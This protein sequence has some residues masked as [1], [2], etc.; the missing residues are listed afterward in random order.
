MAMKFPDHGA[1]DLRQLVGLPPR[2][3]R[4]ARAGK[5][6][7]RIDA[8]CRVLDL[9]D[10]CYRELLAADRWLGGGAVMRWLARGIGRSEI[11]SADYDYF[12]PSAEAVNRSLEELLAAGYVFRCFRSLQVLCPLCGGPGE[13]V[14]AD[15]PLAPL[16]I[17]A[18]I[19]CP[20][21][22][23]FDP[24]DLDGFRADRLL[25]LR[26]EHL[27]GDRVRAVELLSPR[28][29]TIHLTTMTIRPTPGEVLASADFSMIQFM[30][31]DEALYFGPYA[32]TDL[33]HRRL[34][35]V[36]RS[37]SNYFRYRKF[38]ALGFRPDAASAVGFLRA[39]FRW[40][41]VRLLKGGLRL[42]RPGA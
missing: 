40:H 4:R 26:P 38:M 17:V 24:D 37:N 15:G 28:G 39:A 22:G 2:L 32:W 13:L 1:E 33:L 41:Y 27:G 3:D 18:P 6:R 42:L 34:R 29:D 19:R 31:D 30:L 16:L 14:G 36:S 8:L 20:D 9:P 5:D 11:E 23:Q 35:L 25:R 10:P 12:F 21:C 7:V